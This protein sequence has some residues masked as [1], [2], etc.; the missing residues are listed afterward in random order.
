MD[1]EIQIVDSCLVAPSEETPT[2]RLWLSSL[3]LRVASRGHTPTVYFYR[4]G[5][6]AADFFDVTKLRQSM[7]KALVAFYP[8]AGRLDTDNDGRLE[9]NCNSEGALFVVARCNDLTVNDFNDLKPSPELRR[10]FV[11]RIEP[12]TI[13]LA[14]QVRE[15]NFNHSLLLIYPNNGY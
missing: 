12:P 5:D 4:S 7:A 6:D 2:K 1:S 10:M 14:I 15:F 8:L 9:I 11:P 3:D 13:V